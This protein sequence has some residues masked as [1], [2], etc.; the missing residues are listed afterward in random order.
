MKY[1][2]DKNDYRQLQDGET[3]K[4]RFVILK[5]DQF[6]PEYQTAL[7]QLFYAK[8]GF[9][10]DPS[11]LGG[12]VFGSL[13]DEPYQTRREYILGVAT[14]EAIAEWERLYGMSRNVFEIA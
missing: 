7:C 12:K 11:K 5:A 2:F 9:G 3:Y 10:C 8:G 6:K 14:E 13:Y 4:D 1:T